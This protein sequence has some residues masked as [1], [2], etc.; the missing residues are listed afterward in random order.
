[1]PQ[2]V[3]LS[4][5][6]VLDA[7]LTGEAVQRSIAGQVEFWARLGRSVEELLDGRQVRA[8]A[9]SNSARP[10]SELIGTMETAEGQERLAKYLDSLPFPHFEQHPEHE[11]VLIRTEANGERT[12]G[13]FINRQFVI[14]KTIGIPSEEFVTPKD[15]AVTL[16]TTPKTVRKWLRTLPQ[17]QDSRHTRYKWRKDDPFV[18]EAEAR[19]GQHGLGSTR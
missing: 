1:M 6:L 4:D 15:L 8:L 7:R 17:F 3:K 14:D 19:F 12:A 9:Q 16:N 18:R 2:P 10:L 5:A 11:T 13:R